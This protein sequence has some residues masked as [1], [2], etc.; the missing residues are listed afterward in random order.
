[1]PDSQIWPSSL[2][3][4]R[5]LLPPSL[6]GALGLLVSTAAT[7]QAHS[8]KDLEDQLLR[9]EAYA[10]IVH[11]K[12]PAFKLRDAEGRQVELSD[13][14]GKVVVLNFVYTNCPDVCPLHSAA[15]ASIQDSVN[16]TPMKELV[17]FVTITTDPERDTA[18][19]MQDYGP[20]HGLDPVNWMFLTSGLEN[21]ATTRELAGCY[22]LKFT[23]S[24]DGYQLHGVV[25]HLIDKSGNIRARYHGLKFD[26]TNMIVHINALTNDDH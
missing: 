5:R 7:G 14:A 11:R 2:I 10:E 26:E 13:L 6:V 23:R 17:H 19:V 4:P 25:T 22:G 20:L 21:P 16:S 15:I 3:V 18:P 1:M 8:L 12:A 9:R 24:K